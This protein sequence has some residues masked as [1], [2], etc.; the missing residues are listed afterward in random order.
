MDTGDGGKL[1]RFLARGAAFVDFFFGAAFALGAA[2]D[3]GGGFLDER[4]RA[5]DGGVL[6]RLFAAFAAGGRVERLA[7]LLAPSSDDVSDDL[8]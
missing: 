2:A 1:A 7:R 5:A 6:A 8:A 4:E 3:G